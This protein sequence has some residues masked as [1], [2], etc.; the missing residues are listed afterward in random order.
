MPKL[1]YFIVICGKQIDGGAS[2]RRLTEFGL[3]IFF[4]AITFGNAFAI[5]L[6]AGDYE[7]KNW[8]ESPEGGSGN[9]QKH[10]EHFEDPEADFWKR[11]TNERC[12]VLSKSMTGNT[13]TFELAC[14]FPPP[15]ISG[16][17]TFNGN[18]FEGKLRYGY[19]TGVMTVGMRGK[20]IESGAGSNPSSAEKLADTDKKIQELWNRMKS[21][22]A[23]GDIDKALEL[24]HPDMRKKWR[25]VFG[26]A[27]K[28][29]ELLKM[30]E[31]M[32]DL[33]MIR[34]DDSYDEAN[35]RL[36]AI[37]DGR[38]TAFQVVFQKD[39]DDNWLIVNF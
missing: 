20:K 6:A 29:G 9:V 5:N 32:A 22:L 21:Y 24:F 26:E 11:F 12:K 23:S 34:I 13:Y 38:R 17:F 15:S 36:R 8:V 4:T 7:I 37:I 25:T 35:Y 33:T 14:E 30:V 31:D 2:M 16:R 18:S 39:Q 28:Q 3:S 1:A 10:V 27:K 19:K